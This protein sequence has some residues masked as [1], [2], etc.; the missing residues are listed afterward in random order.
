MTTVAA[1][2]NVTECGIPGIKLVPYGIH[3]CHVY[4]ERQELVDSLAPYFRT[5]L[6]LNDRCLWL[7]APPLPAVAARAEMAKLLPDIDAIIEWGDLRII[8]ASN[9]YAN[10]NGFQGK[11][12]VERWLTEEEDALEQG[13][14]GLRI[15]ANTSFV[16]PSDSAAWLDYEHA[17]TEA[18]QERR[19]VALSSFNLHQCQA[20][21]V[22]DII[23]AH[24]FT[25]DRP[26]DHWQVLEPRESPERRHLVHQFA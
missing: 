4:Q 10:G 17:V 7:T 5:G 15:A 3:L 16:A 18:L 14:S 24:H 20:T 11:A 1:R 9:W 22:F 8:D 2:P 26:D 25:L 13:Y 12:A 19:I 6:R 23:R 21:D